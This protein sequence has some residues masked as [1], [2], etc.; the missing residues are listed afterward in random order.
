LPLA[1]SKQK[2]KVKSGLIIMVSGV[3][4]FGLLQAMAAVDRYGQLFPDGLRAFL[5]LVAA[6]L[7][8]F[9][10]FRVIVGAVTKR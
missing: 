4:P 2:S 10:L 7:V 9:G 8:L 1:P 3:L 6:V 5:F